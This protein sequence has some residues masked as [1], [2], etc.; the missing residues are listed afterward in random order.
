MPQQRGRGPLLNLAPIY[1]PMVALYQLFIIIT[2]F[3]QTH[4]SPIKTYVCGHCY[5]PLF[6]K[7]GV[8]GNTATLRTQ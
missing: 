7:E 5:N 8:A 3:I 6:L 4:F 1:R 2:I